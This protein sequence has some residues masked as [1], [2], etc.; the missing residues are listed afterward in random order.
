MGKMENLRD[1]E[2]GNWKKIVRLGK[3]KLARWGNR[4]NGQISSNG[5]N[6]KCPKWGNGKGEKFVK[7]GKIGNLQ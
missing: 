2:I 1:G 7:M 5:K 6:G 3:W 4:E